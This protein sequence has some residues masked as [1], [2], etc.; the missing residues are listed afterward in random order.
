[1][2]TTAAD[3]AAV[4]GDWWMLMTGRLYDHMI[5]HLNLHSLLFN[6]QGIKSDFDTF[7]SREKS[8]IF[9]SYDNS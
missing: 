8:F 2:L 7:L 3:A 1:M 6:S 4:T 9:L 5:L